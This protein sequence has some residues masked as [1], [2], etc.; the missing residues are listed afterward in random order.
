MQ[1][2]IRSLLEPVLEAMGYELVHVQLVG[3]GRNTTLRV[4]IDTPDGITLADCETVSRQVSGVL[5]VEDPVPGGYQLEVSSPG[6]DRP[7]VKAAHFQQFLGH[8]IRVRLRE[9]VVGR[10][11]YTGDLLSYETGSITVAVD[12][13]RHE[14][15]LDDI[16]SARVVPDI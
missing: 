10:R 1:E 2:R 14:L 15:A 9:S 12:G 5:D 16:D 4:Y 11:N 7:L 3:S 8:R 6:L 13:E